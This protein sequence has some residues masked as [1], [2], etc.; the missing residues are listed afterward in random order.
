SWYSCIS[1]CAILLYANHRLKNIMSGPNL[2]ET[3]HPAFDAQPFFCAINLVLKG[4]RKTAADF[5]DQQQNKE[6]RAH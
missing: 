4:R 2:D 6:Q 5:Q 3:K 1:P